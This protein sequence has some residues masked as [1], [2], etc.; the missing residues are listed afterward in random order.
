M[1]LGQLRVAVDRRTGVAQDRT[2]CT[3]TINEALQ[4]ISTERD[5][6]WMD[7]TSSFNTASVATY[8][9]PADWAD[10]RS[11]TVAGCRARPI[12]GADGDA[13][14]GFD[15]GT[16]LYQ[17]SIG[18]G[19]LTL[20]PTPGVVA[21]VHRYVLTEPALAADSDTPLL[22]AQFHPVLADLAAHM[23]LLRMSDKRAADFQVSYDKGLR[24]IIGSSTR[25]AGTK[26]IQVRP[27]GML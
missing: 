27:G 17:Y 1:N 26:R 16:T 6:P 14:A 5:W 9:L 2:S 10:T 24:R 20:Y 13:F 3:A 8:A 12:S 7:G 18:D 4:Q 22:P 25:G 19:D 15:D 21:V 11:L 23:F